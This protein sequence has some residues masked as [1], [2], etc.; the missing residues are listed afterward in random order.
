MLIMT[1][2]VVCIQEV[3]DMALVKKQTGLIDEMSIVDVFTRLIFDAETVLDETETLV[4]ECLVDI[5]SSLLDV[6]RRDISEFLRSMGVDEMITVVAKV[7]RILDH[8]QG[9]VATAKLAHQAVLRH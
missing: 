8:Q 1:Q 9:L 4:V 7:K 6:S 5:D 2:V 3:A